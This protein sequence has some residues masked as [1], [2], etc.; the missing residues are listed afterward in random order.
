MLL[1]ESTCHTEDHLSFESM[2]S[3]A[4]KS[5]ILQTMMQMSSITLLSKSDYHRLKCLPNTPRALILQTRS[6]SSSYSNEVSEINRTIHMYYGH[7]LL[8]G[9]VFDR[10]SRKHRGIILT[11]FF[12]PVPLL[13]KTNTESQVLCR[14]LSADA[15]LLLS[16]KYRY[17]VWKFLSES[18][19]YLPLPRG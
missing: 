9:T 1:L 11:S 3:S 18:T 4:N 16:S 10:Y 6:Y 5:T 8:A 7:E 17:W 19:R 15:V 12:C 13:S 2:Y 14:F